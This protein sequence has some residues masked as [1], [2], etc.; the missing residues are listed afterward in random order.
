MMPFVSV[1]ALSLPNII[2]DTPTK[3]SPT[4]MTKMPAH[5]T[6]RIVEPRKATD[7]RA[8]KIMTAP[9]IHI[10]LIVTILMMFHCTF[11]FI[12]PVF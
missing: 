8:V 1:C 12:T 2:S 11:S 10:R 4:N 7:K 5:I 6:L 9:R 3:A